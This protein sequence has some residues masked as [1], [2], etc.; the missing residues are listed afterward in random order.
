MIDDR[1]RR[2]CPECQKPAPNVTAMG[3]SEETWICGEDLCSVRE[4]THR[5]VQTRKLP[6]DFTRQPES[7]PSIPLR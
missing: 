3:D 2:C 6:R 1:S 7:T 4:F 5:G